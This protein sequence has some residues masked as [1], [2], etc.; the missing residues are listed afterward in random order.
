[1]EGQKVKVEI[2]REDIGDVPVYT[3]NGVKKPY[4]IYPTS[5]ILDTFKN[6]KFDYLLLLA[7]GSIPTEGT[8]NICKY[9][10]IKANT[11]YNRDNLT[12]L[13]KLYKDVDLFN[14]RARLDSSLLFIA[15]RFVKYDDDNK[16]SYKDVTKELI[17]L[18]KESDK[19][20]NG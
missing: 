13:F 18:A 20:H 7:K 2:P 3:Y 8:T 1:M 17:A 15:I 12:D 11:H 9:C 4:I 5:F 14:N 10:I 6:T 16:F 19:M